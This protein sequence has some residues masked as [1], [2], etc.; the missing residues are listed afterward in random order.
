MKITGY[1][2]SLFPVTDY[3]IVLSLITRA[4]FFVF[5]CKNLVNEN[6]IG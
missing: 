6:K 4:T 5:D 2:V 3:T 1:N